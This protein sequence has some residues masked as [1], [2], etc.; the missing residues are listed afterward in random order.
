MKLLNKGRIKYFFIP[1]YVLV[2]VALCSCENVKESFP[3]EV[4]SNEEQG[5]EL[6][7]IEDISK[8]FGDLVQ[9]TDTVNGFSMLIPSGSDIDT[10]LG[11]SFVKIS[12][13]EFVLTISYEYCP[14]A[15]IHPEMTEGLARLVPWYEYSDAVDQYVGY[16]QS[17]FLLNETWQK[18]NDVTLLGFEKFKAG[19]FDAMLFNANIENC[20]DDVYD[21]FSY[22]YVK[23]DSRHFLRILVKYQKENGEIRNDVK[24]LLVSFKKTKAKGSYKVDT[25]F[26]P[27][28][29]DSWSAETLNLY[30]RI[31]SSSSIDW[32]IFVKDVFETGIKETIPSL[33]E[34][35]NYSFPVVLAYRH[36]C[37]DFPM[38][39]MQE[40]WENGKIV[41]LTY[42]ITD[43]NNT[44]MFAH[45]SLLDIYR[46]I[47]NESIRNFAKLAKEFGHPFLFRPCN[48]MNSDWTSYGGVVNMADP[49]IFVEVWKGIYKIFQEE[50]VDNCIWVFNP[51]DRNAPPNEWNSAL[52][53]YPG[54]EY[55]QMIGVTGYNNGTYYKRN[56]ETWREF[57]AI[58]DNIQKE[59]GKIFGKFPWMITEFASSS[60]GGNKAKWI[61]S[62]FDTIGKYPNIKIA[63]WF[64]YADYDSNGNVARPY[65]LDET[66]ETL[67]AFKKGVN[68]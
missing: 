35:L 42:Q 10:S 12:G 18:N 65:W 63:V 19:K 44:D 29:P 33:E 52:A 34:K 37:H 9:Y 4:K 39:F 2:L 55:V 60:V 38:E 45:S 26:Y 53:Y 54:N 62:M 25:N 14:Y 59:Y 16:Y 67:N 28:I 41:E 32:G 1:L 27:V 20:A 66:D 46:G 56:G 31:S 61:E 21:G 68:R 22:L 15:D 47:D 43:N 48:E 58:Y 50:G 57:E 17:R 23:T 51:N 30:N 36:S 5:D 11:K 3:K 40:N 13:D 6:L 49:D 64:S 8:G 7:Q 24:N